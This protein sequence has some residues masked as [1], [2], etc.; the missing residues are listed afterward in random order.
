MSVAELKEALA[1][2]GRIPVLWIPGL[3]AGFLGALFW[4]LLNLAGT[5]FT[6]RLIVIF[7]LILLLFIA[8][9]LAVLKSGQ[10]DG[11][12]LLAGGLHA[13]FRVLLPL[14]V[15]IFGSTVIFVAGVIAFTAAGIPP[16]TASMGVL[17]FAIAV[18][19]FVL[20]IFFDTAAVFENRRVFDSIRRSIEIVA[21]RFGEVLKFLIVSVLVSIVIV[22]GLLLVWEGLLYDKLVPLQSYNETQIQAFTPAQL[23]TLIGTTGMWI[24]A[25]IIFIGLFLLIP[26]L[27]SYKACFFKKIA[28]NFPIITQ[29]PMTG[30]YDSKGRWYK[31]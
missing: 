9:M 21:I 29:A 3:V 30:E 17:T 12:T 28:G 24:T 10:G 6:S 20:T 16:D 1:L 31:Y 2:I 8:G 11:K 22:F 26:I 13:Y 14:L 18:P 27:Y 19:V 23:N 7:G 15:I 4:V 5:F 25:V